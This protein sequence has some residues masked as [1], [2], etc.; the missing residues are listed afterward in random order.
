MQAKDLI[1]RY[2]TFYHM[3]ERNTWPSIKANGLLSTSAVLDRFGMTGQVRVALE[4]RHRPAKVLV[5]GPNDGVVL[6]DQIPMPPDRISKALVDGTTP[7]QWYAFLNGRVFMWAQ[8]ARL[9]RLLQARQYRALEHDVLTVDSG[10]LLKD[11]AAAAWL[12]RMN[13]GT[14]GRCHM[15]EG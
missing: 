15:P 1:A 8:E 14:P 7:E 13:S 12:C 3:A 6:R 2:P 4:E 10:A 9:F 11:Y 5:G